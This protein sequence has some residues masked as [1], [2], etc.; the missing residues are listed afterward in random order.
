MQPCEIPI[1]DIEVDP[2]VYPRKRRNDDIV[3]QYRTAV[4][5]LPPIHVA[6][7]G[8]P[9]KFLLVDGYHRLGALQLEGYTKAPAIIRSDLRTR[10]DVLLESIRLNSTHGLQLNTKEKMRLAKVLFH[11]MTVDA[12]ADLLAV[13]PRTIREWTQEERQL[14]EFKRDL[15][16]I[17]AYLR[18]RTEEQIAEEVSGFGDRS[19][20]SRRLAYYLKDGR[21]AEFHRILSTEPRDRIEQARREAVE[22]ILGIL[23]DHLLDPYSPPASFQPFSVWF[24]SGCD[25]CY[26]SSYPGR[27]AGQIV[28]NPLWSYVPVFG[29]VY[30]PFA[31]SGTTVDVCLS[32]FRRVWA[33][34]ISPYAKDKGVFA[35]DITTGY[36]RFP[37]GYRMDLVILDPPYCP[38][39][40]GTTGPSPPTSPTCRSTASTT[41]W[42]GSSP[43][44]WTCSPMGGGWRSSSRP[45]WS[46]AGSTTTHSSCTGGLPATWSSSGGTS[47]RIRSGSTRPTT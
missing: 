2:E 8:G 32:M 44:Q 10:R 39:A 4:H 11:E 35:H 1:L 24:F 40:V 26:G 15:R 25:D 16:M 41:R 21:L 17:R 30:D 33:S 36:P 3:E 38:S 46:T 29:K 37:K 27:M 23:G 14:E 45:A 43:G 31:A 42:R 18:G 34:D 47:Y 28:E 20:V 9:G 7:L 6:Q 12:L 22:E 13:S 19:T 5:R